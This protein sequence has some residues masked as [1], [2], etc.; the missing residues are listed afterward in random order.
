MAGSGAR[1][2]KEL[3]EEALGELKEAML[4]KD[5]G[6]VVTVSAFSKQKGLIVC[7]CARGSIKTWDAWTGQLLSSWQG[8]ATSV[9][10]L[11]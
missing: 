8:H 4:R 7:G 1:H 9:T 10:A 6:Y 11:A 5:R 3:W 2:D